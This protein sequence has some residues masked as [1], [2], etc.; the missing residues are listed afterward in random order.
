[1]TPSGTDVDTKFR[2]HLE[3]RGESA[4]YSWRLEWRDLASEHALSRSLAHRCNTYT[5]LTMS[6]VCCPPHH[7]ITSGRRTQFWLWTLACYGHA[8]LFA[9]AAVG[10]SSNLS[11]LDNFRVARSSNQR[12]AFQG[13]RLMSIVADDTLSSDS[14]L[15]PRSRWTLRYPLVT[16]HFSTSGFC[17]FSKHRE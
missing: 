14:H 2:T 11:I 8:N 4:P 1:M 10:T 12:F 17:S 9:T 5:V 16:W 6:H 7:Q 15:V 13:A 3:I